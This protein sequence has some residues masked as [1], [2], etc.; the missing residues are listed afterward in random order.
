MKKKLLIVSLALLFVINITA[1]ATLS[2]NRWFKPL[3][4]S[5]TPGD[6]S[7]SWQK[8]QTEIS[9]TPHQSQNMQGLRLSLE[10]EVESI[11]QQISE[12]RNTLL[13][14]ARNPSPDLNRIDSLIE[15]IGVLQTDIQKKSV[16]NLLKDKRLLT[17]GQQEKYFSLF[18]QHMQAQGWRHGMRGKGR[19]GPRWLREDHK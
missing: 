12:K 3:P 19:R 16:R 4:L 2:Y 13:E 11:R 9:L 5:D 8:L 18:E 1:L 7:E 17:P 10:R 6:Q 14:E 15:E